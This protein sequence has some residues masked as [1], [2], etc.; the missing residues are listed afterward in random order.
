MDKEKLIKELKESFEKTKKDL[1]FKASFKEINDMCGLEDFILSQRFVS[2]NFSKQMIHKMVETLYSWIS[3]LHSWILP[4]SYDA[5]FSNECKQISQEE[6]NEIYSVI[7]KIMYFI[8]KSKRID[9]QENKTEEGRIVDE[10]IEFNKNI[11]VPFMIKYNLKFEE[12]W[13]K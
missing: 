9:F 3:N 8:R 1:K 2:N 7:G 13:M 10:L 11:F 4:Q 12:F 6:K 5:I